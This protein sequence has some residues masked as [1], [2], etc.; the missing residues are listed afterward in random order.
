MFKD[1]VH[2][3]LK[4]S[5]KRYLDTGDWG[6]K[7]DC[8]RSWGRDGKPVRSPGSF[9]FVLHLDILPITAFV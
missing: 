2:R 7:W 1:S 5:G 8:E 3:T 4:H 9:P 6:R